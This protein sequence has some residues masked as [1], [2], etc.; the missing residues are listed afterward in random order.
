MRR[1]GGGGGEGAGCPATEGKNVSL[2]EDKTR[3]V[4]V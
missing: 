3:N 4:S 1:W 2:K